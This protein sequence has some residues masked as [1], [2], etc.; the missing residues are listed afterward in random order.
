MVQLVLGTAIGYNAQQL[1]PFAKSLR[2]HYNGHIAMVVSNV[3]ESLQS[4]FTKY[5]IKTFQVE[6]SFGHDQI[7][8][9]RHQFHRSVLENNYFDVDKVFLC[10]TRDAVF[11]ANP[12]DHEMTTELEFFMEKQLYKNCNCNS[13]WL[14][15]DY[16]GAYGQTVYEEICDEYIICAGTT[17]GTRAGIIF[18]LDKMIEE[19]NKL[20]TSRGVY[21]V[22]QPSHGFL[23]Y[24]GVFPSHKKYH[25]GQGP[26][27][28]MNAYTD[29]K[30]DESGNLLN[31]DGTIC[32]VVHQWDR[33]GDKKMIFENKSMQ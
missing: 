12:F 23:I 13:W 9:I 29:M 20:N 27:A 26:V 17:M 11:Q 8:N 32:P 14:K 2:K 15:G 19:L 4:F 3:D 25:S 10:D 33:T 1:E 21:V 16:V 28:T 18:Y 5:D 24:S 6:G 31:D 22:D 30:F 7:C